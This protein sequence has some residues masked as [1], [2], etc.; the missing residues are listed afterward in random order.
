MSHKIT[1][2]VAK[3]V[4]HKNTLHEIKSVTVT[5]FL[6]LLLTP[7]RCCGHH[8]C[9]LYLYVQDFHGVLDTITR[10]HQSVHVCVHVCIC[11]HKTDVMYYGF[12]DTDLAYNQPQQ[13]EHT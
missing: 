4:C 10:G 11:A 1:L 12:D 2:Q 3:S 8:I 13:S 7:Q 9:F 5:L 6:R